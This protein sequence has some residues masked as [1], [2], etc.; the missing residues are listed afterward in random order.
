[1][2]WPLCMALGE[3]KE[4]LHA[5]RARQAYSTKLR[6][7][8]VVGHLDAGQLAPEADRSAAD[9]PG[10]SAAKSHQHSRRAAWALISGLGL[11]RSTAAWLSSQRCGAKATPRHRRGNVRSCEPIGQS[12]KEVQCRVSSDPLKDPTISWHGITTRAMN[13]I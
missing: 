2:E 10:A 8:A 3:M 9:M 6:P 13:H 7:A 5:L 12:G 11:L 1:M 4:K